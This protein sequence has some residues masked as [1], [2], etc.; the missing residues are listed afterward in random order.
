MFARV[1]RTVGARCSTSVV[2]FALRLVPAYAITSSG[3]L[4]AIAAPLLGAVIV[5]SARCISPIAS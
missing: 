4:V 3:L 2:D 5:V 1:H